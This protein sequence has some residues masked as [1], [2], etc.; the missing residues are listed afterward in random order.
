MSR[1]QFDRARGDVLL[2][3]R[4]LACAGAALNLL[5]DKKMKLYCFSGDLRNHGTCFP[6]SVCCCS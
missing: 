4:V 5:W 6:A 2:F 3:F 1:E